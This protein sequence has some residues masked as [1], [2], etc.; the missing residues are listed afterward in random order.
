MKEINYLNIQHE[1]KNIKPEEIL[2]LHELSKNSGL[3][4]KKADK[5][6]SIVVMD[7]EDYVF[8]CNRQLRND[9]HYKPLEEP[10]FLDTAKEMTEILMDLKDLSCI[11][12]KQFNYLKPCENPRPRRFY[13]LPKIHKPADKW[14]IPDRIPAGRPIVSDCNSESEKVAEFIDEF[15]KSKATKHPSYIKDTYNFVESVQDLEIPKDA[16]LITL[17]VESMYTNILHDKGLE[18]IAEAFEDHE[19]T[20]KFHAIM[21][22]LEISL[23][24]NDFEFDKEHFLQTCGTSMGKKWAP[25]YCD[26]YMAKF[27]KDAMA[28]CPLKPLLYERFLDDVF[29]VWTH[30]R[31]EFDKFLDI[32]NS[33]Q[34]PIKFKAEISSLSANFLDTTVFK[35]P[36]NEKELCIKVYFKLQTPINFCLK[37]RFT[38]STH[39]RLS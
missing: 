21:K 6:S 29:M 19:K 16:L 28:K 9:Q 4:L 30:G 37:D 15:I 33:H 17:D 24:C 13:T 26:I 39:R 35:C 2:A 3:V 34:P 8:E 18:A 38:L 5:G 32:F 1:I 7:Q 27:E 20:P 22:L 12:D 36:E 11:S 25:H 10:I 31:K 14:T 23:K